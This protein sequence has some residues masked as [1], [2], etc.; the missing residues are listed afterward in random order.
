MQSC[1]AP[2]KEGPLTPPSAGLAASWMS[3]R[4]EP[5]DESS[6]PAEAHAVQSFVS[7]DF[8]R[9]SEEPSVATGAT[10]QRKRAH[11]RPAPVE[12]RSGADRVHC[13]SGV[14]LG[15]GRRGVSKAFAAEPAAPIA[16]PSFRCARGGLSTRSGSG[17]SR[18]RNGYR[19]LLS[20]ASRRNGPRQ[21]DPAKQ[22]DP[23]DE[24][25]PYQ[26]QHQTAE[27]AVEPRAAPQ[28][29]DGERKPQA[30]AHPTE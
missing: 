13:D 20:G 19:S 16:I 15:Q 10:R 11:R 2:G 8:G 18:A 6:S 14:G 26:E 17:V 23:G 25:G 28:N 9:C 29:R 1:P 21:Q 3:S 12:L 7:L 24:V 22:E 4:F 5:G 27:R 30:D